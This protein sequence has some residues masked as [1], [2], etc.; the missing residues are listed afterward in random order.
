MAKLRPVR[1]IEVLV[2][3]GLMSGGGIAHAQQPDACDIL[4]SPQR[5]FLSGAG[6]AML[7]HMCG[8]IPQAPVSSKVS[9]GETA[10]LPSTS[11]VDP[12]DGAV[13]AGAVGSDVQ[14]NATPDP[15]PNTTQSEVTIARMPGTPS[16]LV[17]GWNDSTDFDTTRSFNGYAVSTDGGITWMDRGPLLIL[18]PDVTLNNFGDP[19]IRAHHA[20][21]NFYYATIAVSGIP[22]GR[23]I[24]AVYT[25][26]T[27][28]VAPDWPA[29]TNVTPAQPDG[30]LEDKP[31]MDVDNSGGAFDGRVYVCWRQFYGFNNIRLSINDTTGVDAAL[32]HVQID[33]MSLR[34][35]TPMVETQG[36]YVEVD[37]STG[38]V[39]VAWENLAE[40]RTIRARRSPPGGTT[41]G[42]EFTLVTLANIGHPSPPCCPGRQVMNGDIR[43][44]EFISSM[45]VSPIT[46]NLHVV[47]ASDGDGAGPDE[48]DVYHIRCPPTGTDGIGACTT[49]FKLNGDATTND[50]WHPFIE[51]EPKNGFLAAFWY[52]RRDDPANLEINV[53]K[54]FSFDDGASWTPDEKVTDVS[55]GV[56][57]LC[58]NFDRFPS[59][60]MGE[61][62]HITSD[63]TGRFYFAWGDNRN[64]D[65]GHPD[66]DVFFEKECPLGVCCVPP[67]FE[68][69]AEMS[70]AACEFQGGLFFCGESCTPFFG[71]PST[72]GPIPGGQ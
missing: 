25:G 29:A 7:M 70:D 23:R 50:Q 39:Y 1:A 2:V 43:V 4:S 45:T 42:P 33:D 31:A 22:E 34:N 54:R 55:F 28:G 20:S 53:Y 36:C 41:F 17:A 56:P 57:P 60:Y 12:G 62:N 49:P 10:E 61:Y 40:P 15:A 51:A 52:D 24:I 6:E 69:C 18:P 59:C 65:S 38:D 14:V 32:A 5:R 3:V 72:K 58:P 16:T 8:E 47:Y 66:P 44:K 67:P 13:A 63:G 46:G 11:P 71:C 27:P 68:R 26:A 48:S 9:S 19:W 30:A 64:L 35:P 21:T 37:Q